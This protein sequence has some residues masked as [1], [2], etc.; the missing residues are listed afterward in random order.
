[1]PTE[2]AIATTRGLPLSAYYSPSFGVGSENG[3]AV[4]KYGRGTG[5]N[6]WSE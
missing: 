5:G 4:F 2:T 1:M 3:T 6:P